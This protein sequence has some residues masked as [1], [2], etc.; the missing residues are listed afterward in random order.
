[1]TNMRSRRRIRSIV[2]L[3]LFEVIRHQDSPSEVL[4]EEDPSVTMPRKF[5]LSDVV[6]ARIRH[7]REDVKRGRRITDDEF[8]DLVGLVIRRPDSE[9]VFR[10]IGERLSG[11]DGAR[12]HKRW[13]FFP[14]R[15]RYAVA[16]RSVMR[17]LKSL[18]G[19]RVGGFASGPF[20]M[21]GRSLLFIQSDPGGDAC[22]L[23]SGL[24]GPVLQRTLGIRASVHHVACES[25]GDAVCR[26]EILEAGDD[27][28]H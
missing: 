28:G 6:E 23:V 9:E 2:A 21:E 27:C 26:W 7:A 12:P 16:R 25:R 5:G 10:R 15:L 18:F 20:T 24:C 1:M 19:R 4:E 13:R 3:A 8:H 14:S 22:A 17:S 11:G